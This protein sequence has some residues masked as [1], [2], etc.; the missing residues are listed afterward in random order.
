VKDKSFAGFQARSLLVLIPQISLP[1][2]KE[3]DVSERLSDLHEFI[4]PKF[5]RIITGNCFVVS[6][7]IK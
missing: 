5:G 6:N 1:R 4:G 7:E 3:S 2:I